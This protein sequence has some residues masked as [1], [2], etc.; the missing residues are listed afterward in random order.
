MTPLKK[1]DTASAPNAP[2]D[3]R[4]AAKARF[5]EAARFLPNLAKLAAR[6]ARDRRVP[7][8]RKMGLALL[9]GYLACPFDLIPD[10]IPILG[11]AV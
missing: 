2:L 6:L 4:A 5:R 7:R 8:S 11:I 9:A 1:D 3:K 10:F